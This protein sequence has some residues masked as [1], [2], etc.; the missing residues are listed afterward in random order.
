MFQEQGGK[1]YDYGILRG[2]GDN[3]HRKTRGI[4]EGDDFKPHK[5]TL[6]VL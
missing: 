6:L 5:H 3:K 1:A 2:K 4:D